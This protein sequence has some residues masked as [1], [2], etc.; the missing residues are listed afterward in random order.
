M[1]GLKI[2]NLDEEEYKTIMNIP[3]KAVTDEKGKEINL[4]YNK[5]V[6]REVMDL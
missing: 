3:V 2:S 5:R 4:K 6:I 1:K